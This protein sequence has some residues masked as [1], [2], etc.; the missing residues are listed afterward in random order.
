MT[1]NASREGVRETLKAQEIRDKER[2]QQ[3]IL[4]VLEAIHQ[5]L[6]VIFHK[7]YSPKIEDNWKKFE[8]KEESFYC[9]YT[10][11]PEDYLTIFRSNANIIG[12]INNSELR[13]KIVNT[14]MYLQVLLYRYEKNNKLLDQYLEVPIRDPQLYARIVNQLEM[15]AP[16]LREEHNTFREI[17]DDFFEAA[18][19]EWPSFG[20]SDPAK[21][22]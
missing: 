13:F 1:A 3:V 12:Q 6:Y 11:V 19:K 5:E 17:V 4:G 18:I 21:E 9:Y 20:I 14:Y 16:V 22:G 15:I 10:P 7:L 2:Q 8:N